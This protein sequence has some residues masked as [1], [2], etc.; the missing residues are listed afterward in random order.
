MRSAATCTAAAAGVSVVLY[1][2]WRR[3]KERKLQSNLPVNLQSNLPVVDISAF[4]HGSPAEKEA[5]AA[6]WD[7][8]FRSIGF[9]LL[10]G[11]ET[12]LPE[13][14]IN[15]LRTQAACFF[16]S[17]PAEKARAY[18]DGFIGFLGVGEENVGASAG[19][20]S[21]LPDLCESLSLSGFQEEGQEWSC[22]LH[23]LHARMLWDS[24]MKH[25]QYVHILQN[26]HI[27]HHTTHTTARPFVMCTVQAR[28]SRPYPTPLYLVSVVWDQD[29]KACSL[30][31]VLRS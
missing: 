18:H 10:T 2:A 9:C 31:C 14:V 11:Y 12:L 7:H 6:A 21:A 4:V 25:V 15:E 5:A 17:T 28:T 3:W 8:A 27:P 24:V 30:L 26:V 1:I 19:S 13:G 16:E 23:I 22:K 20:P 29:L